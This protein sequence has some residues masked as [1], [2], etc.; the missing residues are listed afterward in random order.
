MKLL[1]CPAVYHSNSGWEDQS[2][3]GTLT[4][5]QIDIL[6]ARNSMKEKTIKLQNSSIWR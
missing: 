4:L 1:Q 6:I 2:D 5:I 3:N